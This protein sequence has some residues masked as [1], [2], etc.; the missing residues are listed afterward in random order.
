MLIYK[1]YILYN[2]F[3]CDIDNNIK[4]TRSAG[5]VFRGREKAG[6]L[7][8]GG[9]HHLIKND[10]SRSVQSVLKRR[11]THGGVIEPGTN[12]SQLL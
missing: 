12:K 7:V 3:F 9:F 10:I 1:T 11:W 6:D 5:L 2:I 4:K 8:P